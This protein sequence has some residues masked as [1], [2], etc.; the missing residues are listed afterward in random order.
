MAPF[1]VY[2]I[3]LTLNS[4]LIMAI[5]GIVHTSI[6]LTLCFYGISG[7]KVQHAGVLSYIDP[8]SAVVLDFWS[9]MRFH[10]NNDN[11]RSTDTYK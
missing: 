8:L 11:R 9:S 7:V 2:N 5:L 1:V 6:A 4:V 10:H 3:S